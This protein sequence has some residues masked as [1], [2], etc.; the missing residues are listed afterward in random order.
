MK[1]EQF[2]KKISMFILVFAVLVYASCSGTEKG[3]VSQGTDNYYVNN[4]V[5]ILELLSGLENELKNELVKKFT[6]HESKEILKAANNRFLRILP[7][8]PYIGGDSNYLTENLLGTAYEMGFYEELEN[9]GLTLKEISFINQKALFKFTEKRM[10][11]IIRWY[12]RNFAMTEENYR[13]GAAESQKKQ[14]KG[15]SVY[16]VVESGPD[17][18]FDIGINFTECAIVKLFKH[19]KKERYLPYI[20][21]NDYATYGAMGVELNRTQTISNG[22]KICDFRFKVKGK[23]NIKEG[24]PPESLPEFNKNSTG[25]LPRRKDGKYGCNNKNKSNCSMCGLCALGFLSMEKSNL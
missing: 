7:D 22:A 18:N 23:R 19:Y 20:C 8:L 3:Q 21:L 17:D 1:Q 24:W 14:Y 16:E 25:F 4:K 5:E 15:D 10:N 12:V 6:P 9:R 11:F 2:T 13:K